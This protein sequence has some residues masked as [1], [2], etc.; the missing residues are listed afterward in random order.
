MTTWRTLALAFASLSLLCQIAPAF[1][2]MP[3]NVASA[4]LLEAPPMPMPSYLEEM[5]DPIFNSRFVRVTEPGRRLLAQVRCNK[6][7]CKHR[8]SSAQAWNA[9]QSLLVIAKGC[10]GFCFLDGRNFKPKFWRPI[11]KKHDCK[12]HPTDAKRIICVYPDGIYTWNPERNEKTE[13]ATPAGYG[14]LLF[15]PWKGNPSDDGS[16]IG[17]RAT[18]SRGEAVAFAFNIVTGRKFPDIALSELDGRNK[19]VAISPSARYLFLS[20]RTSAGI[21]T[22][23]VFSVDGQMLQHWPKHHRPGHGDMT[24]DGDGSDV[25]IGI[26]KADPDKYNVIKRR[27][28]DGKVTILAPYGDARHVSTRNTR[29]P[30]WAF[31][32][33][34]GNHNHVLSKNYPAPFYMEIVALKID[35][36]GEMLRIAHTRGADHNYWSETHGSPSPDGSQVIWSSNWGVA[37]GPVSDYVTTVTIPRVSAPGD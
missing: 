30:G 8:Y 27:L 7:Y 1:A 23:Y 19:L 16:T 36:S 28:R 33:Y 9:D 14:N 21:E 34:Q 18:N 37:G 11:P 20:Q 31:V 3:S 4:G 13:I 2:Q 17:L 5:R 26:S 35:G 32:S 10:A 29:L 12:W 25:Y 6:R 24:I 15:G 22:A